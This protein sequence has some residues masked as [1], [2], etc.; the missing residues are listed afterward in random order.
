MTELTLDTNGYLSKVRNAN[1][2]EWNLQLSA[3]GLLTQTIDPRG[4]LH[5]WIG[6]HVSGVVELHGFLTSLCGR[7]GRHCRFDN[8]TRSSIIACQ[9]IYHMVGRGA[10]NPDA[11]VSRTVLDT[12]VLCNIRPIG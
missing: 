4:G 6:G 5:A 7:I 3:L 9:I 8:G 10:V 11:W 12:S 1:M 2:E